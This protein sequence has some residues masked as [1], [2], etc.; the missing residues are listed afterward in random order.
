MR[1]DKEEWL[2]EV[3]LASDVLEEVRVDLL[4]V[5]STVELD[6]V[7]VVAVAEGSTVVEGTTTDAVV[8]AGVISVVVV[9]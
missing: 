5:V 1:L 6:A 7:R 4:V 8:A 9:L 2:L 3:V